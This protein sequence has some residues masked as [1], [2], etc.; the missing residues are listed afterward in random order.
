MTRNDPLDGERWRI[1]QGDALAGSGTTGEAALLAGRC[2]LGFE[3]TEH[4]ATVACRRLSGIG[5]QGEQVTAAQ[6]SL[7]EA[8]DAR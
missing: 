5:H 6:P 8:T 3:L 4:F 2:F 1:L 7:F